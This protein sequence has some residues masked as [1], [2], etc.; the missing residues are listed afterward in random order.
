MKPP[1]LNP[2]SDA[3]TKARYFARASILAPFAALAIMWIA[4]QLERRQAE[5]VA[6]SIN[7]IGSTLSLLLILAG[8][9][10]GIAGIVGGLRRG[11]RDTVLIAALGLFLSGGFLLLTAWA[12]VFT[13]GAR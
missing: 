6:S 3:R 4:R 7:A 11:S 12:V 5:A 10:F 2:I 8:V 1:E 13:A 9:A